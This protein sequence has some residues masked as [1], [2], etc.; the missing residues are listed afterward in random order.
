MLSSDSPG[1]GGRFRGIR[2]QRDDRWGEPRAADGDDPR[3]ITHVTVTAD[4]G[5]GPGEVAVFNGLKSLILVMPKT[6]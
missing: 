1:T 2:D 6:A 4:E 3:R 5:F